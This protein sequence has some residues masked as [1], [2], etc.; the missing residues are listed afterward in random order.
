MIQMQQSQKVIQW[1]WITQQCVMQ[2]FLNQVLSMIVICITIQTILMTQ[3]KTLVLVKLLVTQN[4]KIIL[5]TTMQSCLLCGKLI[6]TRSTLISMQAETIKIQLL[7]ITSESVI[8]HLLH[9]DWCQSHFMLCLIQTIGIILMKRA[10]RTDKTCWIL[11]LRSLDTSGLDGIHMQ[12]Q[13][14]EMQVI[15]TSWLLVLTMHMKMHTTNMQIEMMVLILTLDM[16]ERLQR[17][18]LWTTHSLTNLCS[19]L[20]LKQQQILVL[21]VLLLDL[22]IHIQLV[23]QLFLAQKLETGLKRECSMKL[24]KKKIINLKSQSMLSGKVLFMKFHLIQLL[25]KV[26]LESV[27]PMLTLLNM[28]IQVLGIL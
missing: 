16:K 1:F 11:L 3:Q 6:L 28:K 18:E 20:M 8:E 21:L 22:A 24:Q 4:H 27:Q 19:E 25:L 17:W 13:L 7:L 2:K 26:N 5:L 23:M 9:L 10:I 12:M 14:K 15:T